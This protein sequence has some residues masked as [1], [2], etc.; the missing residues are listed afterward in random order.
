MSKKSSRTIST[1]V[2]ITVIVL[3]SIGSWALYELLKT[4]LLEMFANFGITNLYL[5]LGII[6]GSIIL[7]L[8]LIGFSFWHICRKLVR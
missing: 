5:V 7:L 2:T 8:S 1:I 6:V 3:L 4:A